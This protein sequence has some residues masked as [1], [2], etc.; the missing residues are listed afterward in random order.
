[1][2]FEIGRGDRTRTCFLTFPR[3]LSRLL[4]PHPVI[5][6]K[7]LTLRSAFRRSSCRQTGLALMFLEKIDFGRLRRT[8]VRVESCTGLSRALQARLPDSFH[9]TGDYGPHM[10][11]F[12]MAAILFTGLA[13]D[14]FNSDYSMCRLPS[15]LPKEFRD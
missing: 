13:S 14:P 4:R 6:E 5:K 8:P 10:P 2:N 9:D 11:Y 7:H 3:G 1:M 12:Y 15:I